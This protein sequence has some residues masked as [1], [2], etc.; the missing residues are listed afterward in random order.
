[1]SVRL[2]RERSWVRAPLSPFSQLS[3]YSLS[4]RLSILFP[5][6]W[7]SWESV[8]FAT[9]RPR[10][11]IPSSPRKN[12]QDIFYEYPDRFLLVASLKRTYY[13]E[14]SN[15]KF[16][17]MMENIMKRKQIF[18]ILGIVLLAILYLSSLIFALIGSDWAMPFLE[19]S[20]F[21]TVL[22]PIVLYAFL[23]VTKKRDRDEEDG[24]K[25]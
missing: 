12:G 10:V 24:K 4:G 1:M 5:G 18:A 2:T 3:E 17:L 21:L 14:K 9:R 23:L 16:H 22:V 20:M 13:N 15:T 11:R 25:E 8:A 7:L 6:A 19:A